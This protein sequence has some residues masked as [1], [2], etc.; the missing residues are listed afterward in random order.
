M[1]NILKKSVIQLV[2]DPLCNLGNA[3]LV[4]NPG[5]LTYEKVFNLGHQ[6]Q[7]AGITLHV[8][9]DGISDESMTDKQ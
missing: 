6:L 8:M 9:A 3:F 1:D 2:K 5:E 4:I 7:K